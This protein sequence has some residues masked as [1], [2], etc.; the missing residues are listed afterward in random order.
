MQEEPTEAD[1]AL[2]KL[3]DRLSDALASRGLNK[4]Q[5]AART[6]LSRTIVSAAFQRGTL[7]GE[8]IRVCTAS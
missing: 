5:L 8:V 4:T 7:D 2:D 1:A 3:K 6:G